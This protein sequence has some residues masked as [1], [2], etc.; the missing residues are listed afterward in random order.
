MKEIT[1]ETNL[2]SDNIK[3]VAISLETAAQTK[4][5]KENLKELDKQINEM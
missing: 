3:N 4:I 5:D 2:T 1:G